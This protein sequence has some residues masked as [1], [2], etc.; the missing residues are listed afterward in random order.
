MIEIEHGHLLEQRRG[1]VDVLRVMVRNLAVHEQSG[2]IRIQGKRDD[3]S[4]HLGWLLFRLGQPVMAFHLGLEMQ[5]GLEALLSIE[6]DALDVNNQV[7][8]FEFG[9]HP[10]RT[11]MA[12][13]PNSVLHLERQSEQVESGS[14]WSSVRLPSSSWRRAERLEDIEH[15]AMDSEYRRR[16]ALAMDEGPFLL[17][18]GGIYLFDSPD[19]HHMI[20][21]AVELAERGM[22]LLGLFGLPHA[23]TEITKRLPSPQCF[24]LLSPHG[25]YAVLDDRDAIRA[26]I[27]GFQWGHERSVLLMDGLDRLGNAFG[28]GAML[29]LYRSVCDGVRF[30]D[31]IVLCTTDLEMFDTRSRHALSSESTLLRQSTIEHW[32]DDP[33]CLWDHPVLLA[34]DEEEEQWLEAQIRHQGTQVG[35]QGVFEGGSVEVDD[36]TRAEATSA[37]TE[38]VESWPTESSTLAE[39]PAPEATQIGSTAWTP[40]NERVHE[41]RYVIDSPRYVEASEVEHEPV[42]RFEPKRPVARPST[43]PRL[44]SPQRIT[45]RKPSPRLPNIGGGLSNKRSHALAN[46]TRE[47][48]EWPTRRRQK[49]GFSMKNID[50]LDQRQTEALRRQSTMVTPLPTKTLKDNVRSS[51]DL[52]EAS[53]PDMTPPSTVELPAHSAKTPPLSNSIREIEDGRDVASRE[54][55]ATPQQRVDIDDAYERWSTFEEQNGMDSTAL[56][57]EKGEPLDRYAGD[58]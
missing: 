25:E 9:M 8:L 26:A 31:H 3:G 46:S 33:D 47:L 54:Y 55:A 42:Q 41:G 50:R 6:E 48:P 4:A 22:P 43:P 45:K 23:E 10:L 27:D 29:D 20:H 7:E 53:L 14:W 15:L 52:S 35:G 32:T 30:N 19:P 44:R 24:A 2:A 18:P 34:P 40:I 12:E 13:R 58:S 11:V 16:G 28:D 39:A 37:L 5:E 56:Y 38:V 21:L 49:V 17:Q 51:P 1:G 57:N 36:E